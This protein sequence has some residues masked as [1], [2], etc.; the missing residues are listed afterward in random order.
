[1][2]E[3][4]LGPP[5]SITHIYIYIPLWTYSGHVQVV[6]KNTCLLLEQTKRHLFSELLV[7]QNWPQARIFEVGDSGFRGLGLLQ[8]LVRAISWAPFERDISHGSHGSH[9][10]STKRH[11]GGIWEASEKRLG[12]IWE[13]SG[14]HLRGIWKASGRHLG[15]I[16]EASGRHLGGIWE[17][18]GRHLGGIWCIWCI[19]CIWEASERHLEGSEVPCWVRRL[20]AWLAWRLNKYACVIYV[21]ICSWKCT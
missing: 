2:R 10:P 14:R 6:N 20:S 1:M 7:E 4:R 15:G 17:A 12:S 21:Y 16:W 3:W 19:W 11:L 5:A 8:K 18:S 13:A 9:Y